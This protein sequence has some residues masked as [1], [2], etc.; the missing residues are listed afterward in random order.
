MTDLDDSDRA[1]F[2]ATSSP[3]IDV[4]RVG[5]SLVA[6]IL[7]GRWPTGAELPSAAELATEFKVTPDVVR[8]ALRDLRALHFVAVGPQSEAVV[9]PWRRAAELPVLPAYF[10]HAPASAEK[11]AVAA[12]V[13]RVRRVVLAEAA[14]RA[15]ECATLEDLQDLD[16]IVESMRSERGDSGSLLALD[17]RFLDRLIVSTHSAVIRWTANSFFRVYDDVLRALPD[18]WSLPHDYFSYLEELLET[19]RAQD[20]EE[21]ASVVRRHLERT[22]PLVL[23]LIRLR[24]AE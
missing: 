14:A 2:G 5:G 17:R 6:A 20:P 3:E 23:A 24:L 8:L 13:L 16:E 11:V 4:E 9:R 21:T 1:G 10:R 12:D 15:A 22:D 7:A 18:I 19:I